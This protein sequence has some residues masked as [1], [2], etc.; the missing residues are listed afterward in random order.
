MGIAINPESKEIE[1]VDSQNKI[2]SFKYYSKHL[3]KDDYLSHHY[4][5]IFD[6]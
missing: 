1:F 3:V 6:K 2:Q 5:N 4:K